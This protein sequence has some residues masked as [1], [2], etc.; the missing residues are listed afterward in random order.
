MKKNGVFIVLIIMLALGIGIWR[1]HQPPSEEAQ[2]FSTRPLS[3]GTM[4]SQT[5]KLPPFTLTDMQGN[6]FTHHSLKNH[7]SFLTFGY[8][9]CPSLCPATLISMH[10]IAQRLKNPDIQFIFVTINPKEDT[11][12]QLKQHFQ[13]PQFNG[14]AFK[15][16]TGKQENILKL[17]KALGAHIAENGEK[18]PVLDHIEHSGTIFLIN[19]EGKLA[20]IFTKNDKPHAVAN[21]FK[22]VAHQFAQMEKPKK[23]GA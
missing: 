11:A 23:N 19:P 2:E 1:E 8:T 15:G 7:W 22:E 3:A 4:I 5:Y 6:D 17:A 18:D 16:V 20:A 14:T 12:P 9:S 10:Q 21:D 13:Q